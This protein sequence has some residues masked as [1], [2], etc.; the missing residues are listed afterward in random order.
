[1]SI[2]DIEP[3]TQEDGE[4]EEE[5]VSV[6][7]L[8]MIELAMQQAESQSL[9]GGQGD[10]QASISSASPVHGSSSISMTYAEA[11]AATSDAWSLDRDRLLHFIYENRRNGA[12]LEAIRLNFSVDNSQREQTLQAILL[13]LEEE[14]EVFREGPSKI[15]PI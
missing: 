3:N 13:Q 2:Y 10:E 5:E 7:E 6:E 4:V 8:Q 15:F 12:A 11:A 9:D 14:A 1:M